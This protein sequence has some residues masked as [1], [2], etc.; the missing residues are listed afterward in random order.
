M[1]VSTQE[2]DGLLE[3]IKYFSPH[4]TIFDVGS[5]KGEWSDVLMNYRDSS[6]EAGKYT[7]HLFEPNELLLNYTRVKYDYNKNVRFCNKAV[8][9]FSDKVVPFFYFVNENSGL[10]SIYHNSKWDYLPMN[11]GEVATVALESYA[12]ENAIQEID[13]IK[14]DVEGAEIDV[15]SGC[16]DLLKLKQVKFLQVEYSPHYKVRGSV[17]FSGVIDFV[18]QFDYRVWSWDGSCYLEV[19]KDSFV[20]NYELQNFVITYKDISKGSRDYINFQYTQLWNNEFKLNTVGLPKASLALEIGSFE[21]LTT[22]YICDNLLK[23]GGR[24][25]CVDPMEDYYL[26]EGSDD[27][28][29]QMFIGQYER[30]LNNTKD[31]PVELQRMESK[32]VW[33]LLKDYRFDFVYVDGNHLEHAVYDDGSQAI[34]LLKKGGYIL[35]DDYEWREETKRGIDKFLDTFAAMI[36]VVSKNYQVLVRKTI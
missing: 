31:Q 35:F 1:S 22:N 24:I 5:N 9:E 2:K 32:D 36:E 28:T 10:S 17:G 29:N 6:T 16:L 20:E 14:I 26:K 27:V 3:L 34:L 13:I 21:G 18:T 15:L 8:Y 4:W 19:T 33:P 12:K 7:V 11:R 25:I 23:E 30:F